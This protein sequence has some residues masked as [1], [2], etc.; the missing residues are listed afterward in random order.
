MRAKL[1][2]VFT[3]GKIKMMFPLVVKCGKEMQEV[4]EHSAKI[5]D[6]IEIKDLMSRFTADAVSSCAFGIEANSLKDPN[7]II[8]KM[9]MKIFESN[10]VN[11]LRKTLAFLIPDIGKLIKVFFLQGKFFFIM[12]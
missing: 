10:M 2:P 12:I 7:S 9:G 5:G 3:S 11:V 8:K 1:T 6:V 4:T